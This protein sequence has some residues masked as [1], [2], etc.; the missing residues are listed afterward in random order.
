[1]AQK[2]TKKR[3]R[4]SNLREYTD[5]KNTR[6]TP[7]K[8]AKD[9]HTVV[10]FTSYINDED[11]SSYQRFA[12]V[13]EGTEAV[14]TEFI[15]QFKTYE[16]LREFDYIITSMERVYD[17]LSINQKKA[18]TR[19]KRGIVTIEDYRTDID[20]QD[21]KK[22]VRLKL[23][24]Q[25]V[26]M[27][28]NSISES[29]FVKGSEPM[30]RDRFQEISEYGYAIFGSG[31]R[32][33]HELTGARQVWQAHANQVN[34]LRGAYRAFEGKTSYEDLSRRSLDATLVA[35]VSATMHVSITQAVQAIAEYEANHPPT[36]KGEKWAGEIPFAQFQ[37][38][39]KTA[40][41][42][43]N[44]KDRARRVAENKVRREEERAKA[45]AE[46]N[47]AIA[48]QDIANAYV[49]I[50]TD[51]FDD[52]YIHPSIADEVLDEYFEDKTLRERVSDILTDPEKWEKVSNLA[53]TLSES[54]LTPLHS[55]AKSISSLNL[56]S[57]QMIDFTD[58]L[59]LPLQFLLSM[60]NTAINGISVALT[61]VTASIDVMGGLLTKVAGLATGDEDDEGAKEYDRR[62]AKRSS[63]HPLAKSIGKTLLSII[64]IVF[65][66]F[67]IGFTVI[68]AVIKIGFTMFTDVLSTLLKM[69]KEIAKTS[70]VMKAVSNVLNLALTMFFLPFFNSFANEL[71]DTVFSIVLFA[72]NSGLDFADNYGDFFTEMA[73]Q[74]DDFLSDHKEE[75]E[76]IGEKLIN[77]VFVL[78]RDFSPDLIKFIVYFTDTFLNNSETMFEM[79]RKGIK[80]ANIFIQKNLLT[81]LLNYGKRFMEFI[82]THALWLKGV[83]ETMNTIV[84]TCLGAFSV[85]MEHMLLFCIA[86]GGAL[87]ALFSMAGFMALSTKA[88]EKMVSFGLSHIAGKLLRKGLAKYALEGGVIGT[89]LG[90]IMYDLFFKFAEGGYIPATNGGLLAIVAEKETEYIIPESKVHMIRGHNNLILNFNDDVFL[91]D[92]ANAEIKSIISEES[93]KSYYR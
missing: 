55:I 82:N 63:K 89:I 2:G 45:E 67:A 14:T 85:I 3:T 54:I 6:Y 35:V 5:S 74:L 31:R 29:G 18:I 71:L 51:D 86:L 66:A 79:L 52:S 38:W 39:S 68:S 87:G 25:E 57:T 58:L 60:M 81:M 21:T 15:R 23:A 19:L 10:P 73:D 48:M 42:E 17:D 70:D 50:Y 93:R 44:M 65:K 78:L 62:R 22:L 59:S 91:L 32:F 20:T 11:D 84:N 36:I 37:R 88:V 24:M 92:D 46:F 9:F 61:A 13:R 7:Y 26:L 1:M 90:Y 12:E 41:I 34:A 27:G 76:S 49:S 56:S 75:L 40:L 43:P 72:R 30:I 77:T 16:S 28:L 47:I 8:S 80:V 64:G 83:F 4:S 53:T 69:F 33:S